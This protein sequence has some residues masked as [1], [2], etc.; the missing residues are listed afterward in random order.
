MDRE[1]G[2]DI[3]KDFRVIDLSLLENVVSRIF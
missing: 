1:I 2:E 3:L